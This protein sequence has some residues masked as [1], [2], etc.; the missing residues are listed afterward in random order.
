MANYK[1]QFKT[2]LNQMEFVLDCKVDA[3]LVVG[4]LCKYNVESNTISASTS[5]TPT[6]DD[7]IIAQSDMTMEYGHVPVENR[8]YRYNPKVAASTSL[9]KVAVFKVTDVADV[10]TVELNA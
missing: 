8:D 3:D 4:Q 10:Y 9:K 5:A 7:Y 6:T 2:G 1:A